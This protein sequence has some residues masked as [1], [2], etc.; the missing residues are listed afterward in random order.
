MSRKKHN[1]L[2]QWL[3]MVDIILILVYNKQKTKGAE[4]NDKNRNKAT[5]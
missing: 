2:E 3:K 5:V 4:K 1:K